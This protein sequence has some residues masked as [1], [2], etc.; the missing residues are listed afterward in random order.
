MGN[1]KGSQTLQDFAWG[2][3]QWILQCSWCPCPG[4]SAVL[5]CHGNR[6]TGAA[7]P[8]HRGCHAAAATRP[9]VPCKT[10][11]TVTCLTA[12]P[13][14]PQIHQRQVSDCGKTT[15]DR[16]LPVVCC[17]PASCSKAPREDTMSWGS[18]VWTFG[19]LVWKSHP[20]ELLRDACRK[21][22]TSDLIKSKCQ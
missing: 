14:I 11:H 9:M 22:I 3:G 17:S 6:P 1:I 18:A 5:C 2:G 12:S 21:H 8:G 16:G 13:A 10:F 19:K 7:G 4:T 15:S 20:R